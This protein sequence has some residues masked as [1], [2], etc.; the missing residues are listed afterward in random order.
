MKAQLRI[1]FFIYVCIATQSWLARQISMNS[2]STYSGWNGRWSGTA[3][4]KPPFTNLL[5]ILY[6]HHQLIN[7]SKL[8]QDNYPIIQSNLQCYKAQ[9]HVYNMYS[10]KLILL[11]YHKYPMYRVTGVVGSHEAMGYSLC[12]TKTQP[13]GTNEA[14]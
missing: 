8:N 9:L 10:Q 14:V 1:F 6:K 4:R 3:H 5:N 12:Q 13:N 7:K 2:C 11:L